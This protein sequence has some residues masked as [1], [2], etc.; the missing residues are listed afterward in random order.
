MT[1][2]GSMNS[3]VSVT[4]PNLSDRGL[5]QASSGNGQATSNSNGATIQVPGSTQPESLDWL[6]PERRSTFAERFSILSR[7]LWLMP[8]SP[9]FC[10]TA[11]LIIIRTLT[12]PQ[13]DRNR[14][15]IHRHALAGRRQEFNNKLSRLQFPT[16]G[17]Q[18]RIRQLA[19]RSLRGATR[20][21]LSRAL[22]LRRPHQPPA[23]R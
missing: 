22:L 15:G 10:R 13:R 2:D 20:N 11:S 16:S 21:S 19:R 7:I 1:S 12:V 4:L 23:R 18:I 5:P 6:L 9:Q 3:Q 17:C 14:L 8:A